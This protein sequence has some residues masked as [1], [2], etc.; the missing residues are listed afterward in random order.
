M[1][2]VRGAVPENIE[3]KTTFYESDK[4]LIIIVIMTKLSIVD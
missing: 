3:F 1:N 2:F 4:C